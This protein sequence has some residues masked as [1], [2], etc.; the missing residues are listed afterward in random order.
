LI[1]GADGG[2]SWVRAQMGVPVT[3]RPY[4]QQALVA[5]LKTEKTHQQ[6]GWQSFLP[7]GPL[8][9]L[10]LADDHT[11]AMVW[12]NDLAV[13]ERLSALDEKTFNRELS[14]ALNHRLGELHCLTKPV[15]IPL[16]MRHVDQYVQPRLAL[17]GDAAHTIHPLAGQ[18]VNLGLMDAACLAQVL[19]DAQNK[20]QDI[21]SLRVLRRYQR[22][23][24]G[25]NALMLAAM[26]GFKD[27]FG[28]KKPGLMQLR[29]QGFNQV[30][31]LGCVKNAFMRY[32]MGWQGELPAW[33]ND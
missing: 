26:R 15:A 33:L 31:Q 28:S 19:V 8:G 20:Q 6:M 9:L 10:P 4:D 2:Q 14:A 29:S 13:A 24:K 7:T 22:W 23:R 16:I 21:G 3:E 5:V 32:A 18:G 30:N 27:L 17:V 25:D 1:I 11:M 12:S